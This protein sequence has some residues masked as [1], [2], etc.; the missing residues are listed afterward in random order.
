MS[1][2]DKLIMEAHRNNKLQDEVEKL[3]GTVKHLREGKKRLAREDENTITELRA[4]C[5]ARD[6]TITDLRQQLREKE[7]K[8]AALCVQVEQLREKA[9]ATIDIQE[10]NGAMTEFLVAIGKVMC[11]IGLRENRPT[12]DLNV[13]PDDTSDLDG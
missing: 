5:R 10:F 13:D 8:R 12:V 3:Q 6:Y 9:E 1:T 2:E 4:E 11:T 7:D